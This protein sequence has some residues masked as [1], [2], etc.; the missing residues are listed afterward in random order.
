VHN[1]SKLKK[2]KKMA[3]RLKNLRRRT[4]FEGREKRW[5]QLAQLEPRLADLEE[6]ILAHTSRNLTTPKYCA[7]AWWYGYPHTGQEGF[8]AQMMLLVGMLAHGS[9]YIRSSAAYE[10]AY[11]YLYNLLPD[12]KKGCACTTFN[13]P[14]KENLIA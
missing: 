12:C 7:N 6:R 8:K 2:S 3:E 10:A 14:G 1:Y 4:V 13:H 5:K 11:D 9:D